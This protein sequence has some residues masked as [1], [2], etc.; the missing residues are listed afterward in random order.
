MIFFKNNLQEN[1][2]VISCNQYIQVVNIFVFPNSSFKSFYIQQ[3]ILKK[4]MKIFLILK[5]FI[6]KKIFSKKKNEKNQNLMNFI[7]IGYA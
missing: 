5:I 3:N 2:F 4:K 1:V 6:F 7:F